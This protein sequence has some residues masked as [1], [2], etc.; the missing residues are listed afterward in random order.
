ML[1]LAVV[2]LAGLLALALL[3]LIVGL[4]HPPKFLPFH[5][6]MLGGVLALMLRVLR[7]RVLALIL[8]VLALMLRVLL[9]VLLVIGRVVPGRASWRQTRR[10]ARFRTASR[11]S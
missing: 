9:R 2:I 6:L 5:A 11:C 8:G 7:P 1:I 3:A 4:R 10:S